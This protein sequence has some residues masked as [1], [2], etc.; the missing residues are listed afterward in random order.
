MRLRT[1]A[2][3]SAS[4]GAM[5][6]WHRRVFVQVR[7]AYTP[8]IDEEE[9]W[10]TP[11]ARPTRA[12]KTRVKPVVFEVRAGAWRATGTYGKQRRGRELLLTT[13][14]TATQLTRSATAPPETGS[15]RVARTGG[16]GR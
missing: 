10:T 8:T 6:S 13:A 9:L 11:Q 3:R 15:R 7:F 4:A 5:V 16:P 2:W 1:A 14:G 12:I